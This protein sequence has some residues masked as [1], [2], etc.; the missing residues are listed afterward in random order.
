[1]EGENESLV[2]VNGFLAL[3]RFGCL[4]ELLVESVLLRKDVRQVTTSLRRPARAQ[5]HLLS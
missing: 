5:A 3:C 1:M 2:Y 4:P